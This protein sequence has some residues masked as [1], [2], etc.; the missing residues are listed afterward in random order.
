[1]YVPR[2]FTKTLFTERGG[3]GGGGGSAFHDFH[4]LALLDPSFH[5][6]VVNFPRITAAF[7]GRGE[8]GQMILSNLL[9]D[10]GPE[11]LPLPGSAHGPLVG[12]RYSSLNVV[13]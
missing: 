12:S 7:L 11:P 13:R 1:M 6:R 5:K 3:V 2:S 8:G 9:G 10:H 4:F